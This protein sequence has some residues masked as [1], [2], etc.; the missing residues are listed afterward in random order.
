MES[1]RQPRGSHRKLLLGLANLVHDES[2]FGRGTLCVGLAPLSGLCVC[3]RQAGDLR[4]LRG[5]LAPDSEVGFGG[6]QLEVQF[7]DLQQNIVRSR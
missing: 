7:G 4:F 6:E 1:P 3:A 5:G 2:V